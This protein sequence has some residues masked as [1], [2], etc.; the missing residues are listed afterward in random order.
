V[1]VEPALIEIEPRLGF[2]SH[3][4]VGSGLCEIRGELM[5]IFSGRRGKGNPDVPWSWHLWKGASSVV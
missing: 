4:F 5:D 3:E 1:D 2:E